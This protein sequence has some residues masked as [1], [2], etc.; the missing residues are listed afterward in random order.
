MDEKTER[1][2]DRVEGESDWRRQVLIGLLVLVVV[3]AVVGGVVAVVTIK[4]ADLAGID[5]TGANANPGLHQ[6]AGGGGPGSGTSAPTTPV[7]SAPTTSSTAPTGPTGPT[8]STAGDGGFTLTASP[9]A[10]ATS[11][12]IDLDGSCRS[13]P[14]GA[15]L[16]VQRKEGGQWIDFPVT[17]TC[18]GGTFST[19]ILTGHSGVNRFRMLALGSNETSN[20]VRVQVS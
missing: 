10:V 9:L 5:D 18:S 20:T 2:T 6:R 14:S 16:Q 3:G 1:G 11:Q 19:Y 13:V 15:V 17:A 7:T 12:R 8:H 4:A